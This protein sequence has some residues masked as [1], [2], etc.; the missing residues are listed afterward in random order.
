M[1]IINTQEHLG[2]IRAELQGQIPITIQKG[3]LYFLICSITAVSMVALSTFVL[4]SIA[5]PP[6]IL[7]SLP[8]LYLGY[9][10]ISEILIHA[11]YSLGGGKERDCLGYLNNKKFI[12]WAE[13]KII[14]I[15]AQ[16]VAQKYHEAAIL[17]RV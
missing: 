16:N 13:T 6:L 8:L 11:E 3:G 1:T 14:T 12:D 7:V 10:I 15:T 9:W 2:R 17:N 4:L 5:F